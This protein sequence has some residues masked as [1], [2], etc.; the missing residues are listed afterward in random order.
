MLPT[1][2]DTE[3]DTDRAVTINLLARARPGQPT[4]HARALGAG[5]LSADE[6]QDRPFV[7]I[8]FCVTGLLAFAG[9]D[10]IIK[11]MSA[12]YS[13][14]Q[15]TFVRGTV[16]LAIMCTLAFL[17]SGLGGLRTQRLPLHIARGCLAVFSYTSYYIAIS[18]MPLVDSVALYATAPLFITFFSSVFLGET[19]GWRR[20]SAIS[21][22]FLGVLIMLRPGVGVFQVIALFSLLSAALYGFSTTLTRRLGKTE[23]AVA[24]TVYS[25]IIYLTV[26]GVLLVILELI[27]GVWAQGSTAGFLLRGW[28]V[29]TLTELGLMLVSGVLAGVGFFCLAQAY[30]VSPASKVSPFEF[31]ALLWALILGFLVW[32]DLPGLFTCVGAGV[33]ISSGVYIIKREA[34]LTRRVLEKSS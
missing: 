15:L 34:T 31:T 28:Q 5:R 12:T 25:N 32:G 33:V 4:D 9:Q 1:P 23:S 21:V 10:V 11:L 20:W 26:S 18:A 30:R 17:T 8:G 14:W 24:I 19:V 13:I 27:G 6:H 7:G 29:P 2:V 22:G 3:G 16:V